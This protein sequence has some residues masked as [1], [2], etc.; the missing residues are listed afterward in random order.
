MRRLTVVAFL[1]LTA[2]ASNP[3][4][5][6]LGQGRYLVSRQ[7]ATGFTGLGQLKSDALREADNFCVK[8]NGSLAIINT[9]ESQP[10]YILGNYPRAEVEF[11]CD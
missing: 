11:R 4:V 10:P 6:P 5:A 3:G 7:A 1:I 2:C 9:T 8:Q